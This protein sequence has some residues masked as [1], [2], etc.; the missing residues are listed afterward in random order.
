MKR[1]LALWI[2]TCSLLVAV[3]APVSTLVPIGNQTTPGII[4]TYGHGLG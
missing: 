1:K 2:A 3:A 4:T